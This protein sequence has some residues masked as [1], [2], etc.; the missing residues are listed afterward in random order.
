MLQEDP[1]RSD[2]GEA[3]LKGQHVE[4]NQQLIH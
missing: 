1:S 3:K 2:E 4:Q